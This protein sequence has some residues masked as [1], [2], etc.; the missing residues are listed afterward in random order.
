M[1]EQPIVE[2]S[3]I[4]LISID[5]ATTINPLETIIKEND[6][7]AQIANALK[8]ISDAVSKKVNET[9]PLE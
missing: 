1:E 9:S 6:E 2:P 8:I 3:K 4:K 7:G 5:K